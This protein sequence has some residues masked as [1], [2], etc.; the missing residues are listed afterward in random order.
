MELAS[1]I[2]VF[3]ILQAFI[4]GFLSANLAEKKKQ[5]YGA[6][7]AAGFFFGIFG[8][9][10]AAGLPMK[11]AVAAAESLTKTCPDCSET[12]KREALI[13]KYCGRHFDKAEVLS[14]LVSALQERSL[15]TRLRALDGLRVVRDD[16]VL[17]HLIKAFDQAGSEVKNLID[18]PVSVMNKAGH[19]LTEIG[20]PLVAPQLVGILKKGGNSIKL[21]KVI[22]TLGLLR[23]PVATPAL[24]EALDRSDLKS[25]ATVALQRIG[26][27][28]VS[29][30]E[31]FIKQAK[32]SHRYRAE[33]VLKLIKDS[34]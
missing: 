11:M 33:K 25:S 21:N 20:G 31:A 4:C 9:V 12:I 7:F 14:D 32:G 1:L 16:S 2:W 22:E 27:T 13:C 15:D 8:L 10:A 5:G 24:I 23:D 29:S 3:I 34:R 28:A 19:I 6:W 30:L 26:S 17:P 18:P